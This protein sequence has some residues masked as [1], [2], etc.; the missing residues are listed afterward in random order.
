M[1]PFVAACERAA[2]DR[3]IMSQTDAKYK[4]IKGPSWGDTDT[5]QRCSRMD[6]SQCKQ[7]ILQIKC[8]A[9]TVLKQ[10]FSDFWSEDKA[11]TTLPLHTGD[12]LYSR[13]T[14]CECWWGNPEDVLKPVQKLWSAAFVYVCPWCIV[15]IV[16]VL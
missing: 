2:S 6:E 9:A 13:R 8:F 11:D 3:I 10:L 7:R 15:D 4:S 14:L 16:F 1:F 5:M 12:Q